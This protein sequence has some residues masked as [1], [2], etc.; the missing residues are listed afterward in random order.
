MG[1]VNFNYT[2][3]KFHHHQ[4]DSCVKQC[5]T[6]T[7]DCWV[8]CD[9]DAM[10]DYQ[11]S[12]EAEQCIQSCP[13]FSDCPSGCDECLNSICACSIPDENPDYILCAAQVEA[14]YLKCLIECPSGDAECVAKCARDYNI[15]LEQCPCQVQQA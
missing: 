6:E 4:Y 1:F 12:T 2:F 7:T 3:K 5:F 15:L 13:C 8:N 11:C 10:C 9:G 14:A